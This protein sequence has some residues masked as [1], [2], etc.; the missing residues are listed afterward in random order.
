MKLNVKAA[1][2]AA[3]ALLLTACAGTELADTRGLPQSGN[4]FDQALYAGYLGL[5]QKEYGIGNYTSSDAFAR[6]AQ[7]AAS[8]EVVAPFVPND[9]GSH[10]PGLVPE[11]DLFGMTSG[12][13][14]MLAAFAD[15]ATSRL[16]ADAATAQVNYDC[17]VEEQS[18]IGDFSESDQPERAEE[19]RDAFEAALQRITV[20][21]PPQPVA[22]LPGSVIVFFDWDSAVLSEAARNLIGEA[23]QLYQS[24]NM[25]TVETVG[26]ADK[27]GTVAYNNELSAARAANVASELTRLGVPTDDIDV[28]W[29]GESDPLVPTADGV[30]EPQN[31]RVEIFLQK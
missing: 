4:A 16:A 20:A 25:S 6:K 23:A 1:V 9:A 2:V 11:D 5:A 10:P 31:R 27:S 19:C 14:K 18:Y 15:G 24:G 7:A 17:W 12:R 22:V 8:G 30:R 28:S 29:R 13:E 26:H 3:V 21:P